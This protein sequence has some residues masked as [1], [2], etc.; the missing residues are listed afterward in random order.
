MKYWGSASYH[1][2]HGKGDIGALSIT[3]GGMVR[4]IL[5]LSITTGSMV[6]EILGLYQLPRGAW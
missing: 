5:G 4:E 1:G 3:T 2:G 6:R